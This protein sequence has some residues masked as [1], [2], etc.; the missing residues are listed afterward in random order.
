MKRAKRSRI[1]Q[2]TTDTEFTPVWECGEASGLRR[3]RGVFPNGPLCWPEDPADPDWPAPMSRRSPRQE[4]VWW[5]GT[6]LL[7][8]PSQEPVVWGCGQFG[9]ACR[10]RRKKSWPSFRVSKRTSPGRL[11]ANWE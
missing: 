10:D 2:S 4:E 1:P 6:F 5:R 3:G 11:I 8:F 7:H 9:S